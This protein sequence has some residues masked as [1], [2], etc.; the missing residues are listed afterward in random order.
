M[1]AS[2]SEIPDDMACRLVSVDV[3]LTNVC[4][5]RC[6]MC[7]R[8][9]ITRTAGM[10][11]ESTFAALMR[12]LEGSRCLVTFSGMGDPLRHSGLVDFV[13]RVR[14]A[15]HETGVVAHPASLKNINNGSGGLE[16]M[17]INAPNSI[18]VSFPSVRRDVFH[19][20]MPD[21]DFEEAFE[22]VLMLREKCSAT[23]RVSGILTSLNVNEEEEYRAFWN[24][25][26]IPAWVTKCHSRGANLDAGLLPGRGERGLSNGICSLFRFHSFVSWE[27]DI[28][29][30]CHDL[31]GD[32][33]ISNVFALETYRE[34][35]SLKSS[36][37]MH[38]SRPPFPLCRKCDE[39][40]RNI[41]LSALPSDGGRRKR[42]KFFS[43]MDS[44]LKN[45]RIARG[46][47]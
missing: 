2:I 33:R 40:L 39:P 46:F 12:F 38:G 37:V 42:K 19:R 41:T 9:A 45:A 21:T 29:A 8:K 6:A 25:Y 43:K 11:A 34:L 13:A 16:H 10:M 31:A 35:E 3:E 44:H 36:L 5:N 15:G 20:L 27:G 30:C 4:G 24:E 47:D 28:L 17:L 1:P 23:V 7:P 14:E 32:T 22:Q 26:A 18:T